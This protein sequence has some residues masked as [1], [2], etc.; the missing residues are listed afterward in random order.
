M[1]EPI[2]LILDRLRERTA[3]ALESMKVLCELEGLSLRDAKDAIHT[4]ETWADLRGVNEHAHEVASEIL[5]EQVHVMENEGT[6][7]ATIDL[8][9]P[10]GED[11]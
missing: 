1:G 11:L 3:T 5:K 9:R 6:Y 2:E 10:R 8:S 7:R 4:S